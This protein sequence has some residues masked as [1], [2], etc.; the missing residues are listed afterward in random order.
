[1]KYFSYENG[2]YHVRYDAD[3]PAAALT[4]SADGFQ[5]AVGA[6]GIDADYLKRGTQAYAGLTIKRSLGS[7]SASYTMGTYYTIK[8]VPEIGAVVQAA[9]NANLYVGNSV[10]GHV[11]KGDQFKATDIQGDWVALKKLDDTPVR[12]WIDVDHLE[13][14]A[15]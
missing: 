10:V 13:E 15:N 7:H 4:M 8:Y 5:I 2:S 6:L 1:M 3:V 9:E 11:V 12:G 14:P